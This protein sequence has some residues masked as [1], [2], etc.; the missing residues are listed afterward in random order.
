MNQIVIHGRLT[1]DVEEK[2][3]STKN[4]KTGRLAKFTVASN[5]RYGED[6]SFFECSVF[7]EQRADL[8]ATHFHKGQEIVVSGE[9]TSRKAKTK[10]DDDVTYW[11]VNVDTFDF[12]GKK[13]DNEASGDS[14]E[15]VD[16]DTPF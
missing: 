7:G 12:C 6:A 16:D 5:P 8:I 1:K 2:D 11:N 13:A 4:G 10:H 15:K 9:M 14:F 3:Y